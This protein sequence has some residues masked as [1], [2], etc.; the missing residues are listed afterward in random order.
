MS[1][2][3]TKTEL[4]SEVCEVRVSTTTWKTEKSGNSVQTWKF[5]ENSVKLAEIS[6]IFRT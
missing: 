2:L 1:L 6:G 4:E 3:S 5:Q